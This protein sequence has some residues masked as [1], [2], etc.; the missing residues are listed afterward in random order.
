VIRNHQH[1]LP[2]RGRSIRISNYPSPRIHGSI[3]LSRYAYRAGRDN[4]ANS[5]AA[6][7]T[8]K[9]LFH[10]CRFSM[11][12]GVG[13]LRSGRTLS[14]VCHPMPVRHPI[15]VTSDLADSH[16][17]MESIMNTS[18]EG[19]I[20]PNLPT[21]ADICASRHQAALTIGTAAIGSLEDAL[22]GRLPSDARTFLII[23]ASL[24]AA[25]DMI[26]GD[27]CHE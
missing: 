7:A 16:N 15:A 12:A 5:G 20:R 21:E 18:I 14:P 4:P 9:A 27:Q 3:S 19:D 8:P 6:S 23:A 1:G 2:N 13:T 25:A 26:E 22:T 17:A 24:R 10:A 11:A